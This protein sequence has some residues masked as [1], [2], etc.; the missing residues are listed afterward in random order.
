MWQHILYHHSKLKYSKYRSS[1]CSLGLFYVNPQPTIYFLTWLSISIIE[2]G[3]TWCCSSYSQQSNLVSSQWWY[4]PNFF[5][6]FH[7]QSKLLLDLFSFN[8][9]RSAVYFL[10]PVQLVQCRC[11]GI[12]SALEQ[13]WYPTA[14]KHYTILL[15]MSKQMKIGW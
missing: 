6:F 14:S 8:L 12:H 10:L 4:L 11:L 5:E 3:K 13:G 7:L 9:F 15:L 2:D 1:Y